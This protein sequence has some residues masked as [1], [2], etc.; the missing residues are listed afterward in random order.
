VFTSPGH[1]CSSGSY[2][3]ELSGLGNCTGSSATIAL[4]L[5]VTGTHKSLY[6][7]K[8]DILLGVLLC[9]HTFFTVFCVGI[10]DK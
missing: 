9:A 3:L 2:P 7:N 8:V 10:R 6:I 1:H 4:A 5:S